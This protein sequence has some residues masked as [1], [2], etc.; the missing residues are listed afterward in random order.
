MIQDALF[1]DLDGT[2]LKSDN[3]LGEHTITVLNNIKNQGHD[4]YIA[5]GRQYYSAFPFHQKLKLDTP[6]ITLNGGAIYYPDGSLMQLNLLPQNFLQQLIQFQ[7]EDNYFELLNFETPNQSILTKNNDIMMR[8]FQSMMPPGFRAQFNILTTAEDIINIEEKTTNI[9]GFFHPEKIE[10]FKKNIDM[11]LTPFSNYV[12]YRLWDDFKIPYIEFFP[13]NISKATGI[14]YL[15]N[16]QKQKY[17]HTL[18][19]GDNINDTEMLSYVHH[20]VAM[21]NATTEIQKMAKDTTKIPH[22]REGVAHYL[23]QYYL[24]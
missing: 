9:Y 4:L 10:L 13:K 23:Q 2:L 24:K 6:L 21:Q 17:R 16:N 14:H 1:F 12:D 22:H 18:A 15:L 3:L 19:F 7:K 8:F 5:T 11:L 20:G